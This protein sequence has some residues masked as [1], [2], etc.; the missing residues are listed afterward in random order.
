MT[1]AN[2][3]EVD[4]VVRRIIERGGRVVE[5]SNASEAVRTEL[6]QFLTIT[7]GTPAAPTIEGD[8]DVRNLTEQLGLSA[9]NL[10]RG[11]SIF[12]ARCQE[13]HGTQG[14]GRGATGKWLTPYPRDFRQGAFKFV[15]STSPLARKPSRGDLFHT[16][17]NGLPTSGMPSF[18]MRSEEDRQRLIDYVIF[19]TLRGKVEHD[20]LRTVLVQGEDELDGTVTE[21]AANLLKSELRSWLSAQVEPVVPAPPQFADDSPVA[22]ESIRRGHALFLDAKGAGCVT[23]HLKY[24]REGKLQYDVFGTLIRPG[25]LT[26]VKRKGGNDSIRLYH[27][28]RGGILPSQMPAAIGLSDEQTW[29]LIRFLQALPFADRL[30]PDVKAAVY[31]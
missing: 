14:D 11:S 19:L 1:P 27:R 4:D 24:G 21:H 31:P 29:D 16:L 25:N 28:V 26:E 6:E 30:P 5:P 20:L 7:F 18:G 2:G 17:T 23:C 10:A 9:V 15:S 13:C 12:R 3:G 22:L 8:A